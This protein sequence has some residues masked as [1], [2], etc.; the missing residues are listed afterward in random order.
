L[1]AGE[2]LDAVLTNGADILFAK[3]IATKTV[4]HTADATLAMLSNLMEM[5]HNRMDVGELDPWEEEKE[6]IIAKIDNWG[7]SSIPVRK[8]VVYKVPEAAV[9]LAS[10]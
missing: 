5:K 2:V 4:P 8:K 1:L 7:R 10:D 3:Y 9:A 6:P